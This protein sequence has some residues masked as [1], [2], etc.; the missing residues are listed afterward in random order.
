MPRLYGHHDKIRVAHVPSSGEVAAI[1]AR[2]PGDEIQLHVH[3]GMRL[4][5]LHHHDAYSY[6]LASIFVGA[7]NRAALRRDYHAI[8]DA[9]DIRFESDC[10]DLS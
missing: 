5:D 1:E 2:M 4:G 3:E 7:N 8:M 9:L 10:G 6:E